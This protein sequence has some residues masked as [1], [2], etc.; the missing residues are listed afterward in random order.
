MKKTKS[1]EKIIEYVCDG[2]DSALITGIDE[3]P[4]EFPYTVACAEYID[5]L[6]ESN[7]KKGFGDSFTEDIIDN[8]IREM[9]NY[10]R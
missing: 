10:L 3:L 7:I 2:F 1:I 8:V 5:K 4:E 9:A 6:S